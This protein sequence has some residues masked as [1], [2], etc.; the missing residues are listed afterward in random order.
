MKFIKDKCK[1]P[2]PGKQ[3]PLATIQAENKNCLGS[4]SVEKDLKVF[5]DSKLNVSQQCALTAKTTQYYHRLY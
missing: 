3:E 5:V 1:V 2:T 4:S